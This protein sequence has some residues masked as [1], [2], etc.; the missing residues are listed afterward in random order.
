M[1]S[2]SRAGALRADVGVAKNAPF[3]AAAF[4][5]PHWMSSRL[6]HF[7]KL[8]TE[9]VLKEAPQ[10]S[11]KEKDLRRHLRKVFDLPRN[12]K[13]RDLDKLLDRTIHSTSKTV[14][15]GTTITLLTGKKA[16]RDQE[17]SDSP[18]KMTREKSAESARSQRA[19][20]VLLIIR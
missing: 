4:R 16:R 14:R 19:H 12:V 7:T 20:N 13:K 8:R 17:T 15:C 1:I 9:P 3:A 10:R 5:S 18:S 11:M 6:V 2:R